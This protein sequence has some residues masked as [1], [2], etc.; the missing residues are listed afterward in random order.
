MKCCP[1]LHIP[2]K[3]QFTLHLSVRSGWV[4]RGE[5]TDEKGGPEKGG[6]RTP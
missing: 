6:V 1:K 5:V 4:E 2:I 3:K